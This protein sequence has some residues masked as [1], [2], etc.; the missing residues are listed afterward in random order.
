MSKEK[1]AY[2]KGVSQRK[3]RQNRVM[4]SGQLSKPC[5]VAH[6]NQKQQ[7]QRNEI[8]GLD[9]SRMRVKQETQG[10]SLLWRL[11]ILTLNFH[12][13]RCFKVNFLW[14]LLLAAHVPVAQ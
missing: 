12:E 7:R 8:T 4:A 5:L 10:V 1:G 9:R 6:P 3:Y 14:P 11:N 2:R 13:T